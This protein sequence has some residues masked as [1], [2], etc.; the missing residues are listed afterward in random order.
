MPQKTRLPI[1]PP[2]FSAVKTSFAILG[3]FL[4][5]YLGCS[6][7]VSFEVSEAPEYNNLFYREK[8]WTGADIATSIPLSEN[9]TL[10]LFG[11]TW[12]GEIK[13]GRHVNSSM[14]SNSIAI[15]KE[16]EPSKAKIDFHY[17]TV[18]G[19]PRPWISPKNGQRV[20][21]LSRGGILTKE[22]LYLF[23]DRIVQKPEDSSVFGFKSLGV[24]MAHIHN[25]LDPPNRWEISQK[26]VPWLQRSPQG[27]EISFGTPMLNEKGMTYFYGSKT[28]EKEK[29]RF[30]LLA[31]VPEESIEDFSEWRFYS[32]GAWQED[33][34]KAGPIF[35]Q[36]GA[37]FS[38]SY[39]PGLKR[40][41][42]VYTEG[43]LS[44]NILIRFSPK[45]EGP[46]SEPQVVYQC[47]EMEWDKDYFCY[48]GK[49]HPY[50]P[51]KEDEMLVSYVCNSTDFWKM[52]SDSRIYF[53][54]FLK[55]K[56]HPR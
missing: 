15:Q 27:E 12:I 23:M 13:K 21:W 40:Y 30:M 14:I 11:D 54:K 53:P 46:W 29:N 43:G 25:P 4:F 32:N 10:W 56:V 8:G 24:V 5:L 55:I 42:A 31:R 36:A 44:K 37:E 9:T 50:L 3:L 7:P 33:F 28:S 20:F 52:A 51:M 45:P 6:K 38:V 39:L 19:K 22:G 34:R 2:A 49:G 48:A 26:P 1:R 41:A 18:Q 17:R 35:D 47:P 16:K